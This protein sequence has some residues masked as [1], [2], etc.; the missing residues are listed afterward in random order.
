M[1]YDDLTG[2]GLADGVGH[3]R[4]DAP[5]GE[6]HPREGRGERRPEAL[7]PFVTL[8]PRALEI[9]HCEVTNRVTI[10]HRM[11]TAWCL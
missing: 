11:F 2:M 10:G 1:S 8:T 9:G 5:A 7:T 4:R 3:I 6:M